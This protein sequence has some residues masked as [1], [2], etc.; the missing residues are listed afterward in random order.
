MRTH[1]RPINTTKGRKKKNAKSKN[2]TWRGR[3][4]CR[5]P[6]RCSCSV[7]RFRQIPSRKRSSIAAP[8]HCSAVISRWWSRRSRMGASDC[9]PHTCQSINQSINQSNRSIQA[10]IEP[11]VPSRKRHRSPS[12]AG[13]RRDSTAHTSPRAV[14][15]GGRI[16][17]A[18]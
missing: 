11:I 14:P 4:C 1:E 7:Q 12:R 18:G 17:S 8:Y 13:G 16:R 6:P 15:R 9:G 2:P 10:S 3:A 5:R